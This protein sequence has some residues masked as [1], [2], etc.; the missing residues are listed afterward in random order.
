M[1]RQRIAQLTIELKQAFDAEAELPGNARG[2]RNCKTMVRPR[3][4][5]NT[6]NC[7][8]LPVL[9]RTMNLRGFRQAN[10]NLLG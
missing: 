4:W 5:L 2:R 9:L 1:D 10:A 8:G 3:L 6:A 7:G